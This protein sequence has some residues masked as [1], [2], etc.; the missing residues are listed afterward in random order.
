MTKIPSGCLSVFLKRHPGCR[1][2]PKW[3]KPHQD[4]FQ[5]FWKGILATDCILSGKNYIMMHFSHFEKA[6][7]PQIYPKWPK[8]HQD[9]FQSF[10][11]DILAKYCILS[12]QNLIRML[13]IYP[14]AIYPR[15]HPDA[16]RCKICISVISFQEHDFLQDLKFAPFSPLLRSR[17][18]KGWIFKPRKISCF[19]KLF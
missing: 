8:P 6:S 14:S 13:F 3:P 17:K 2:R 7:R 11:K 4:V 9:A 18:E 19:W 10:W 1:L 15:M 16:S 12:G 5:S